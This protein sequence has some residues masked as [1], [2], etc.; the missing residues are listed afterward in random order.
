MKK[1]LLLLIT[2]LFFCFLANAQKATVKGIIRDTSSRENLYNT[3][4][5][6]LHSKDSILYKFTRSDT[7]GNFE[8]KGLD[9]G[10]YVLLIT[11]PLYA[12]YVEVLNIKDS[13]AVMDLG[14]IPVI[15]K[16]NLLKEVIVRQTVSAIRVKGD[17]TEY[18]ADSFKVQ[19]NASVE[20]LLKKLPGIQVDRNGQITAQGEKVQ[21]VL[22]DGEEFFGDDPTLVTQNL[23]ADMIDK[24]QVF[25]KKSDQANFT[26]IDDG[27]KQKTINL[28]LKDNKKNGYFGRLNL[29]AGTD[30]YHDNQIMVNAFKGKQKF[31]AYG[32]VSNT[33]T[34]GLN[35]QDKG[36][37]GDSPLGN[38]DYDEAGGYFFIDGGG[39]DLDSWD[40]RYNGQGYP[41]V[42]T[43]GLHYNNKW[44]DD[45][46]N[47]NANYK[48]LQLHVNGG[49]A[50]NSQSILPDSTSFYNNSTQNFVNEILRNRG[51]ASYE[52]QFDSSSSIKIMADGGIDH[53]ITSNVAYSEA[54]AND[55]SLINKSDR[56]TSTVGDNRSVNSSLLWKKKLKKKGRTI[57]FNLK[58]NFSNNT[59]DGYLYS[60]NHYYQDGIDTREITDQYKDNI[61]KN[62]SFDS[63]VTYSEPLSKVSSLILNYGIVLNNSN[64]ERSSYN[65]SNEGKYTDIDSL[66]SNDYAFNVFTHRAGANYSL[67][68]KKIKFNAGSNVGFTSFDQK[69]MHTQT[70]LKR[71]FV[72]WYPQAN[73][74][75][76]FSQQRR[77]FLR[78]NG[79][80]QQPTIQQIQPIATNDDPLNIA[81]GNPDLKPSFRN[82]VNLGFFDFKVLTERNIWTNVGYTFTQNAITSRDFVDASTGK[83]VYQ[84]V[85]ADGNRSLY[86]YLD[87]GFKI[88]KIDTRIGLN[89]NINGSRYV[90]I[91]ND[92]MNVTNSS[93]YSFGLNINKDKEKKYSIYVSPNATY[94]IS[95]SSIQQN[96]ET[97]YWTFTVSTGADIFLPLKFQIHSDC[98]FNFRQKTSVFENNNNAILWNAWVGKK[99]LKKDALL[100]KIT[101]HD[102]LNQ[103]IG[104]DRTVNSNYISQN[105]YSTIQRFFLLSLVWNF[106]KAGTPGPSQD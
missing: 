93:S 40:G 15:L 81:I 37:Y 104:F 97:K 36:S 45:K 27:E 96:L 28:K 32:I 72:N 64:S 35:W 55:K 42:Q 19:E 11:Y 62:I 87:Y 91:V 26:G 8:L 49:S 16:A 106:T 7:K 30:G 70:S 53:K 33:G 54:L 50:T 29:G 46:Q 80:T 78:Y 57:S 6:L 86:A 88:K 89:S 95:K 52:Y 77:I 66:Y 1:T 14:S 90:S 61:S 17:T 102:L 39:D 76:N 60:D 84:S 31:A 99:L 59:S 4:I 79:S 20:D 9:T 51:N 94:T 23:R 24:V 25:D 48:I 85:N 56:N 82:S 47:L 100:I 12:D 43:G 2:G 21:K 83:R 3:T 74:S 18:A 13:A 41:L 101:G 75:Y 98:D 65:K 105:T 63:K 5:S 92:S 34:S 22:V 103:N 71:S 38:A 69:D 10:K 67:F 44:N 58:E 73:F 68:K